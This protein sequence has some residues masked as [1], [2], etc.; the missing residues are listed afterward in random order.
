MK[1]VA[2]PWDASTD[3][4]RVGEFPPPWVEWNDQY[5]DTDPRLLAGVDHGRD[6][7]ARHPAGR[8]LGPV[9]RRRALAV[10]L[11]QLRDRPRRV[12]AARPGVLRPQAQRGQRRAQPRRLR[13]QPV[14][15]LWRRGRDRRHVGARAAPPAGRQPDRDPVP[16]QRRPDAD[17]G[18]RARAAPSAATTTPTCQDNEISWVDWRPDDAWLDIYEITRTALRIRREHPALRQRHWFEGRPAI[19]RRPQGPR[20]DPPRPAA[21]WT[22]TTGTTTRLHM[23]GMFVSGDPIR[24]PGP[25]GEQQHDSVVP[26]LA[27]RFRGRLRGHA[28]RERVGPARR[29][30]ALHRPGQPDRHRGARR[31]QA[32]DRPAVAGAAAADVG[33]GSSSSEFPRYLGLLA[34]PVVCMPREAPEAIGKSWRAR[35]RTWIPWEFDSPPSLPTHPYA[36]VTTPSSAGLARYSCLGRTRTV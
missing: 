14:L 11:D 5:R 16:V 30:R 24:E 23:I 29:G 21:R 3:G 32:R 9:R 20:L 35:Q 12:H 13:Q 18:R 36:S 10:Q 6:P 28:P 1:L 34:L 2:E 33:T 26:A 7:H 19:D 22:A 8:L 4:Y 17:R 15:E 27:Q 25:R 31:R